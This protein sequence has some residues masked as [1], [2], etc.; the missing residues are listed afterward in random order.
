MKQDIIIKDI[1]YSGENDRT[2]IR[3]GENGII[4]YAVSGSACEHYAYYK[5]YGKIP[6]KNNL[7]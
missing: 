4:K 3:F 6:L 2:I 1:F 7:Y 5:G